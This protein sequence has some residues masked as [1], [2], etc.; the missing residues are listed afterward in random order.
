MA[1]HQPPTRT[2]MRWYGILMPL[3]T[4]ALAASLWTVPD[5]ALAADARFVATFVCVGGFLGGL[6][7]AIAWCAASRA[8]EPNGDTNA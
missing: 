7:T 4:V 1:D 3:L 8:S 6:T 2:L 5:D